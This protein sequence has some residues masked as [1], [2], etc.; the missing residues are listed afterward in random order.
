MTVMAMMV[1]IDDGE[2][3]DGVDEGVGGLIGRLNTQIP[4]HTLGV[5]IVVIVIVLESKIKSDS[6]SVLVVV[7][8]FC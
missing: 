2:E 4:Y 7:L 6:L 3:D 5:V 1:M 8:V